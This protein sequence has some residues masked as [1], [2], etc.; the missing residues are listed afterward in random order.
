MHMH[1]S[2]SSTKQNKTRSSAKMDL[3]T[4]LL[5]LSII[6]VSSKVLDTTVGLRRVDQIDCK[7]RRSQ[8]QTKKNAD[9]VDAR[10]RN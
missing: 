9:L 8:Q 7:M 5:A 1:R 10:R 4:I 3:R 2:T 6:T